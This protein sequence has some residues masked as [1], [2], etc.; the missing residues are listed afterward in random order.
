MRAPLAGHFDRADMTEAEA[1]NRGFGDRVLNGRETET[2]WWPS[3]AYWVTLFSVCSTPNE[4]A[5][6]V[7]YGRSSAF[8]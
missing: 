1:D 2:C 5:D 8:C 6:I 4:Y 7:S 3:M